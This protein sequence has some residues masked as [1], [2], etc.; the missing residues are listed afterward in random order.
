MTLHVGL[1]P[2]KRG[3]QPTPE[4]F[5]DAMRAELMEGMQLDEEEWEEHV[6]GALEG[7]DEA[8]AALVAPPIPVGVLSLVLASY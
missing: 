5:L 4:E 6:A 2:P 7:F 1:A 8:R 3:Q